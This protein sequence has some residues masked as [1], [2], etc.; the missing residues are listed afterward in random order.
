MKILD[1]ISKF[2]S[3]WLWH[4]FKLLSEI[5]S[6]KFNLSPIYMN[7]L[8]KK[9]INNYYVNLVTNIEIYLYK[10][11]YI[12]LLRRWSSPVGVALLRDI[13]RQ[14]LGRLSLV[15][16]I[17][18]PA[19]IAAGAQLY[20]YMHTGLPVSPFRYCFQCEIVAS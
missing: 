1:L 14:F 20:G 12:W 4:I 3:L 8:N 16:V 7:T 6:D 11:L 18:K 10:L 2:N 17:S 19:A 9:L 13:F 15:V 5:I